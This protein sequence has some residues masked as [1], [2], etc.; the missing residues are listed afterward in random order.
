[1]ARR[2]A[3][4]PPSLEAQKEVFYKATGGHPWGALT[5]TDV[6]AG[7]AN[8]NATPTF[9]SLYSDIRS[10]IQ[11]E[12]AAVG[13]EKKRPEGRPAKLPRA[14]E[15]TRWLEL[16]GV[17]LSAAYGSHCVT[18]LVKF[19]EHHEGRVGVSR[20][21][22]ATLAGTLI[23]YAETIIVERG[24]RVPNGQWV[25]SVEGFRDRLSPKR[26][27]NRQRKKQPPKRPGK[28]QHKTQ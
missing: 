18:E 25:K 4:Q 24:E 21:T 7:S 1:M 17:R 13:E 28:R 10:L 8:K 23:A 6:T 27:G 20:R 26:P 15:A 2:R 16:T 19:L 9:P 12:A 22:A 11:Q 14:I 3:P 5:V